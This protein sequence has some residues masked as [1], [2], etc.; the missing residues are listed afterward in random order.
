MR[1]TGRSGPRRLAVGVS[2]V[3]ALCFIA[4][5]SGVRINTSPSLPL[6]LYVRTTARNAQL[7]EFC[8][9]EPY[10]TISRERG[11][12]TAGFACPDRAVPLMK[13]IVAQVG[14]VVQMSAFGLRV[15]GRSIP[16]TVPLME[17]AAGRQLSAYPSGVYK[18]QP[19][20]VWVASTHNRGSYDSRY[21]GPVPTRLIR[22]RLKPLWTLH[23]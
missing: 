5:F 17:D 8:P 2:A 7:V 9:E 18:V 16:N 19:G 22:G 23:D 3:T 12:R 4:G 15:N 6:G 20:T 1:L 21:M 10:A 11:Y 14:D 13:R